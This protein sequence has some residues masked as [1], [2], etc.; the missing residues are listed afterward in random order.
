MLGKNHIW[1]LLIVVLLCGCTSMLAAQE[2]PEAV[3]LAGLEAWDNRREAMTTATEAAESGQLSPALELLEQELTTPLPAEVPHW[4]SNYTA[5]EQIQTGLMNA[6]GRTPE[7]TALVDAYRSTEQEG[8]SAMEKRLAIA[9]GLAG[10]VALKEG[11][12][13][14]VLERCLALLEEDMDEFIRARAALA[15]LHIG[16]ANPDTVARMEPALRAALQDKAGRPDMTCSPYG[17]TVYIVRGEALSA[18]LSL[19]FEVAPDEG[20]PYSGILPSISQ[21]SICTG[22]AM[23]A[24]GILPWCP[25]MTWWH[26]VE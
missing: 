2:D 7:Q 26:E 18:L 8:K 20:V 25:W 3:S 13:E 9:L 10:R 17:E 16:E 4:P 19:G 11:E 5:S 6:L 15:L 12:D 1:S 23:L 22:S 21:L 24:C 14:A